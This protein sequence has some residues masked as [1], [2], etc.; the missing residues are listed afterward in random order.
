MICPSDPTG[1]AENAYSGGYAKSNY[2]ISHQMASTYTNTSG[3]V[4]EVKVNIASV[5]DGTSNTISFGER[6]MWHNVVG[7][8]WVGRVDS[9]TDA[10]TVGRGDLPMNTKCLNPSP[11]TNCTRHAWASM[12]P[13]GCNFA[14]ADGAVKF[15]SERIASHLGF[16]A[17]CAGLPN[18]NNFLYQ[19]LHRRNDGVAIP[20]L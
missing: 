10:L 17:S 12:H 11:D 15:L 20:A 5:I 14:M 19:N 13:G 9:R 7:G 2:L 8:A 4:V 3:S 18:P 1:S 16:T 6:D